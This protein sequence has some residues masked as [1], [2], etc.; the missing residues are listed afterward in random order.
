MRKTITDQQKNESILHGEPRQK[1]GEPR[2]KEKNRYKK[3]CTI[4]I[5]VTFLMVCDINDTDHYGDLCL[6]IQ[7]RRELEK[8]RLSLIIISI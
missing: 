1:E 6:I 5:M 8:L 2:Q 7:V 4:Y 3:K